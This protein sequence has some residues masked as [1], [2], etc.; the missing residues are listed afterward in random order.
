MPL[1]TDPMNGQTNVFKDKVIRITFSDHLD[2]RSLNVDRIDLYS[3]PVNLYTNAFYDPIR[4]QLITWPSATMRGSAIWIFEIEEGIVGIDGLPVA[5]GVIMHFK[6]GEEKGDNTPYIRRSFNSEIL[7]IF[8]QHCGQCHGGSQG[9]GF[10]ELQ[11]DTLEGIGDT[12]IA[13]HSQQWTGW[14]RISPYRPGRS[15]LLYKLIGDAR[16]GGTPMPRALDFDGAADPI[17]L[18]DQI[19]LSDWIATGAPFFD[20]EENAD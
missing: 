6:T 18:E 13:V 3:G 12:A 16:I 7:P 2:S 17:P 20:P 19:A 15:Y 14:Q 4:S 5:P 9:E 11:L 10:S 1:A 8:K